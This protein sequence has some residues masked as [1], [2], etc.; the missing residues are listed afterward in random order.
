MFKTKRTQC[1]YQALLFMVIIFFLIMS[2]SSQNVVADTE[3]AYKNIEV[4][5]EVLRK[6]EKNYVEGTDAKALIYGAIKGMV[7]T[8]DPHSSFITAEDYKELMIETKGSFPGVGI[9]ITVKDKVLTVVSPIEGTPAYEA[10]MKAGDQIIMIGDKST[11]DISIREAVKLIRGPKGTKVKLTV[12][13][14]GAEKP[15]DFVIT[16]DV[17]PIKSVRSFSLPSDL[18]YIRISNFQSNTGEDLA[19]ALKKMDKDKELE[20]LI[21]DLRNNPGGLLSQAVKVA[22][23]FLDSGLIVSIKSRDQRE[24]K[25][26]AHKATKSRKYPMIVLVNEGSA[27]ASEIVAGA[28]Q[29]NKRALILGTTT[30]GKGSVQTLFPLSDGSGLRLTTALYYTPSGSSIQASGIEPDIRVAFVPPTEKPVAKERSFIRERDLEGHLE[31]DVPEQ[32]EKEESEEVP[33]ERT[34]I[35]QR[36]ANDNQLSRAIQILQSWNIFSTIESRQGAE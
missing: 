19:K 29:D 22:D 35:Q 9:V 25:S 34:D 24:Q 6:V 18:G 31:N 17:I 12:R 13:R 7:E 16:R 11:K 21:L 23:A 26:V 2:G 3:E 32:E 5:S 27:S 28:L 15:I 8:L 20:G 14:K 1:L 36:I 4:F 10:G 30:F 33:D